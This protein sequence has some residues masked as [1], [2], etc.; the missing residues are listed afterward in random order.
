M[1]KHI[2]CSDCRHLEKENCNAGRF[3]NGKRPVNFICTSWRCVDQ[4]T[5][6]TDDY[7]NMLSDENFNDLYDELHR[8]AWNLM[9]EIKPRDKTLADHMY[10]LL[11]AA[12]KSYKRFQQIWW[13]VDVI[14]VGRNFFI[15]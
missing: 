3:Q 11:T 6:F 5:K 1:D 10:Y 2:I 8:I 4:F 15:K 14:R 12:G 7:I 13:H 9:D